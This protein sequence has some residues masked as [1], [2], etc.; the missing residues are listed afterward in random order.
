MSQIPHPKQPIE[1]N[2]A[3]VLGQDAGT[4][5]SPLVV[6]IGGALLENAAQHLDAFAALIALHRAHAGGIVLV[7]G[8]GAQVDQQ[9]KLMGIETPRIE[10][11]RVTTRE[12]I[13]QVVGV[14]AGSAHMHLLGILAT[15]G[16]RAVGLSLA[17]GGLCQ[18]R[19]STKYAFDAGEVG[20]IVSGDG[21]VVH[22]LLAAGFMPVINSIGL[23]NNGEPLNVNADEAA[24]AIARVT[25]AAGIVLLTDVAGVL[26]ANQQLIGELDAARVDALI[27]EGT[28]T[29]GMIPKVRSALAAAADAGCPATI[30]SWRDV[31]ALGVGRAG[32]RF[33]ASASLCSFVPSSHAS[34]D[35]GSHCTA[36]RSQHGTV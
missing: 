13:D 2:A 32:T 19:H 17:D 1:L 18:C 30:A 27:A 22:T 34:S 20:E 10:G 14:L 24:C 8:G 4:V 31:A 9:L 11:I 35:R 5:A 33:I 29:G 28:I 6:K 36:Q 21:T 25:N 7:H 23:S 16:I 26:D 12:A 15:Q 3:S